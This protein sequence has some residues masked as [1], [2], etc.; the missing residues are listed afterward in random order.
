MTASLP[1][2]RL[3]AIA[4]WAIAGV[5]AMHGFIAA[6]PGSAHRNHGADAAETGALGWC[7]FVLATSLAAAVTAPGRRRLPRFI[8]VRR[9]GA[10]TPPC[11]PRRR[12]VTWCVLRA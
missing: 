1:S 12:P 11:L 6:T 4:L 2:R 9:L 7:V 10:G 3:A 5:V 8:V